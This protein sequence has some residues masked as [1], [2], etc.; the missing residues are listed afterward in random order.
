MRVK[1]PSR[2][3]SYHQLFEDHSHSQTTPDHTQVRFDILN[4]PLDE[5]ESDLAEEDEEEQDEDM[6][7]ADASSTSS[8]KRHTM[9]FTME[10]PSPTRMPRRRED[11]ARRSKRFS[12]P[13]VALQTTSVTARTTTSFVDT[14]ENNVDRKSV[15]RTKRFSLML[16]GRRGHSGTQSELVGRSKGRIEEEVQ[17]VEGK[18]EL[19]KGVAAGKLSE[20]L[21]RKKV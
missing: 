21:G 4:S 1:T 12:L 17:D 20:L 9:D 7:G 5:R 13:A 19:A 8:S 18:S 10:P 11:T 14:G 15:V 3:R 2:P 6:L 16:T